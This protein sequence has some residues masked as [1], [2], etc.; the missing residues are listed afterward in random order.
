MKK[1]GFILSAIIWSLNIPFVSARIPPADRPPVSFSQEERAWL[2]NH[3]RLKMAVEE[4]APPYEYM[5]EGIFSGITSSY[6]R[7]IEQ[8][9]GIEFEPVIIGSLQEGILLLEQGEVSLV[10]MANRAFSQSDEVLFSMPYVSSSLGIFGNATTAFINNFDDVLTRNNEIGHFSASAFVVNKDRT[11]LLV[12][13]HNILEGWI[14]PG[15]HADGEEDLLSVAMREVEEETGQKT[16]VISNSIFSIQA[17]PIKGHMK[18]G[19]YVSAHIHFDVV[20]LLEAD[21]NKELSF[22]KEES[23][24]VKWIPLNEATNES[25]VDFIRPVNKKLIDKLSSRNF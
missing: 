11:R 4:N 16:K 8:T 19:K 1:I 2:K 3:K 22:R 17:L 7:L 14:Y 13:Y 15:G 18:K 10:P 20:Y 25:F 12:V 6:I 21:D 24:G 23:S 9:A 5:K